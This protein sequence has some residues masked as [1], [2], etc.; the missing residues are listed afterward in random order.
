MHECAYH[1]QAKDGFQFLCV[2]GQFS[3]IRSHMCKDLFMWIVY[4]NYE[5]FYECMCFVINFKKLFR[6]LIKSFKQKKLMTFLGKVLLAVIIYG[7]QKG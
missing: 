4:L 3:K 6:T 5:Q 1:V 7:R 2:N